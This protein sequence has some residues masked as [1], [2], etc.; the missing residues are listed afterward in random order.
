MPKAKQDATK[1]KTPR[2]KNI[3]SKIKQNH[4]A[5]AKEA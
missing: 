4:Q 5:K 3:K 2:P 1:T